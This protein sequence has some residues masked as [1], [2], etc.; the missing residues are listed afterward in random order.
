MSQQTCLL[1]CDAMSKHGIC[2]LSVCLSIRTAPTTDTA[3]PT[4]SNITSM[5]SPLFY[6]LSHEVCSLWFIIYCTVR[7]CRSSV[8]S[9]HSLAEPD[10][11]S[12]V[13]RSDRRGGG[14]TSNFGGMHT[15]SLLTESVTVVAGLT[16]E[17][18]AFTG[19]RVYKYTAV[20][21]SLVCCWM[22]EMAVHVLLM[23]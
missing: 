8:N 19:G 14:K 6:L 12:P 5:H 17:L 16:V 4:F 20:L 23:V 7:N 11:R 1:R 21:V 15:N 18:H 10:I 22:N 2:Y 3:Y 9:R 13:T